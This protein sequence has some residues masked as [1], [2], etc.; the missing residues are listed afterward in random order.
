MK[1]F[2]HMQASSAEEAASNAA[3]GTAMF[4]AGGTDLLGTLKDE[5]LPSY[6]ELV[7]D[8][9]SIPGILPDMSEECPGCIFAPRCPYAGERC[10]AQRPADV[11][12][13]GIH[14]AACHRC[15]GGANG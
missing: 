8:L 11:E 12:L 5:I 13:G 4:I 14:R 9:K 3:G 2:T 7:I 6:P 1:H 10:Y 15:K